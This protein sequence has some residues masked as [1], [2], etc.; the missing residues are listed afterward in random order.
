[1]DSQFQNQNETVIVF[2]TEIV[3][4]KIVKYK[5]SLLQLV[6]EIELFS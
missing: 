6:N 3:C 5:Y 4:R 2:Q 1:M